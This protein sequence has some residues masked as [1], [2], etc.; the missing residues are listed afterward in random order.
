LTV[1]ADQPSF[2]KAFER[3]L[4][5]APG[6][7]FPRARQLYLRKYPLESDPATPFRTFLLEES[8]QESEA[9]IVRIRALW[10]KGTGSP[11]IWGPVAPTCTSVGGWSRMNWCP[12]AA[13]AGSVMVG[14][15]PASRPPPST[16]GR[17][18]PP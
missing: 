17:P 13:M 15:G 11:W 12:W 2:Q 8:I 3:L 10:F 14:L 7:V 18:P 16:N 9:G 4:S 6:P 1:S 5:R